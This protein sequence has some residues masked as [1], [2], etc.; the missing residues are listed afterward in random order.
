MYCLNTT[1]H[2]GDPCDSAATD[3]LEH[4][5]VWLHAA[6]IRESKDC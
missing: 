1:C 4:T 3:T 5:Q 2:N 6:D